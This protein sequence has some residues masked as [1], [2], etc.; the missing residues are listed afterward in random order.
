MSKMTRRAFMSSAGA[1][2]GAAALGAVTAG[3]GIAAAAELA[4]GT[5]A[6]PAN[7]KG[8][9]VAYVRDPKRG[10]VA[11]MA[12]DREVTIRDRALVHRIVTAASS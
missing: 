4:A 3:S 2:T 5:A 6:L 11:V 10:E 9:Y 1:V 7:A 8:R 12:G